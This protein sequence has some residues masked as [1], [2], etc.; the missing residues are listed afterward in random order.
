MPTCLPTSASL[1]HSNAPLRNLNR[2]LLSNNKAITVHAHIDLSQLIDAHTVVRRDLLVGIGTPD[3]DSFA[4]FSTFE[5]CFR[6]L[7]RRC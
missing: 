5:I 4:G 2:Q 1:T 6:R 3:K 7:S